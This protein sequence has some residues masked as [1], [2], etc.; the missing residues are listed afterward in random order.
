[1]TEILM[2][3]SIIAPITGAVVQMIKKATRV[4]KR[5]LPAVATLV[6]I[7]LGI[8]AY[9]LDAEIGLRMWAGGISGLAATG[10]FELGKNSV[11]N[12]VN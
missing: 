2:M 6:G 11:N 7:F 10:L 5:Y 3:A 8:V 12:E 4:N 9:F 1:M